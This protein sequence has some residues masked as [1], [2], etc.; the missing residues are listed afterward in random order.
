MNKRSDK[1][2]KELIVHAPSS[3]ADHLDGQGL[4]KCSKVSK[5][6]RASPVVMVGF[7]CCVV[8]LALLPGLQPL[9]SWMRL[10]LA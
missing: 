8:C 2:A 5:P 4:L 6:A 3:G 1:V 10:S 7:C 9:A